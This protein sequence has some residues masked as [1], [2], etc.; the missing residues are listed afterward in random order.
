MRFKNVF[1]RVA[2]ETLFVLDCR[3]S[4]FIPVLNYGNKY[5]EKGVTKLHLWCA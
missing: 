4:M 3:Y 5:C 1:C 2:K